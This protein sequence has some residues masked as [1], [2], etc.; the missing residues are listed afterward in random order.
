MPRSVNSPF[1]WDKP[2]TV[3]YIADCLGILQI[4]I[5][6]IPTGIAAVLLGLTAIGLVFGL[7]RK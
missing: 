7:L 1:L 2:V 6:V 3:R 4:A 5:L